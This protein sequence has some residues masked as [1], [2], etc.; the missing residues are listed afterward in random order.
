M[1]A[2]ALMRSF[3]PILETSTP[4]IRIDPE[5]NPSRY[6]RLLLEILGAAL[7]H[8]GRRRNRLVVDAEKGSM[9]GAY[10]RGT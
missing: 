8:G 1:I 5:D 10:L 9:G 6:R 4:S 2:T 3:D 7:G